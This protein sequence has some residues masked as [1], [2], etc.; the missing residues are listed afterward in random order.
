MRWRRVEPSPR[1]ATLKTRV[2]QSL[3]QPA[4]VEEMLH[5][6]VKSASLAPAEAAPIRDRDSLP[7]ELR[8][9]IAMAT[10]VGQSWAAWKDDGGHI[11]LFV[12]E[13]SLAASRE[14]AAPVLQLDQYS[15]DGEMKAT[16]QWVEREGKWSRCAE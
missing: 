4:R 1:T 16:G 15:E 7:A 12:A 10:N 5:E 13:L 14:R 3:Q 8:R 6:V 11:R 9:I 2:L